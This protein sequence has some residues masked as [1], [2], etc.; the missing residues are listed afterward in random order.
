MKK[1]LILLLTS[2]ILN[3]SFAQDLKRV[4]KKY[5]PNPTGLDLQTPIASKKTGYTSYKE[6]K[7]YLN[8]LQQSNDSIMKLSVIG[9]TQKGKDILLVKLSDSTTSQSKMR[10]MYFARIHG[11]EPGGTEGL[12]YFIDKMTKDNSLKE[13]L[14]KIDFYILPMV[15]VD[16]GEKLTRQTANGIDLNR[17]Q[18]RLETPEATAIRKLVNETDPHVCIDFHEYQPLKSAYSLLS[19]EII[20]VPWDVMF[21]TSGNPNVSSH[22][23]KSIES[24]FLENAKT[25]M[26]VNDFTSHTYYTPKKTNKGI[27]MNIGGASPRST[28]NTFS[29]NNAFSILTESRG[30]G[31]GRKSIGRRIENVYLLAESF[32]NTVYQQDTALLAALDSAMM[33]KDPVAVEFVSKKTAQYPLPFINQIK[34]KMYTLD[35]DVSN[36]MESTV[37]L[38]RELPVKYLILPDQKYAIETLNKMGVLVDTLSREEVFEV[39]SFEVRD[40]EKENTSFK[41]FTPVKVKTKVRTE[42][43]RFPAGTFVI[44]T[45][46]KR[47]RL[48]AVMLEPESSNGFVNYRIIEATQGK[49]LPVFRLMD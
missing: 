19:D 17:D 30:I 26:E 40:V 8:E 37:T 7:K 2:L 11:D 39:Q 35:L 15:N 18:V 41:T 21:L 46:Q 4:Q 28:S 9:K 29:L 10:V 1:Y 32:A 38:S 23:R 42:T 43:K 33:Q 5:Y 36:A 25:K 24:L 13:L 22:I 14:N 27:V 49:E 48:L 44:K 45:D 20:S 16:G 12:L 3:A 6:M 31:L 34:N 47:K